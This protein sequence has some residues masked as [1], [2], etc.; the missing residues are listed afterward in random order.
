MADGSTT[1][2]PAGVFIYTKIAGK[3]KMFIMNH[4]YFQLVLKLIFIFVYDKKMINIC[5]FYWREEDTP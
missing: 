5:G 1:A 4:E 3:M 2:L